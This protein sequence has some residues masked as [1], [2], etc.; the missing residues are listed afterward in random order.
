MDGQEWKKTE[1]LELEVFHKAIHKG[2]EN[3][4]EFKKNRDKKL[5]VWQEKLK[6]NESF[7]SGNIE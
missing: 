4:D 7:F 6:K 2:N 1:T 3:Y 5:K